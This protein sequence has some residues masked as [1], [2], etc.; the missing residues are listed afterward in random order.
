M[1]YFTQQDHTALLEAKANMQDADVALQRLYRRFEDLHQALYPKLRKHG[2]DL[3]AN[4]EKKGEITFSSCA[5]PFPTELMTLTYTRSHNQAEIIEAI[6]GRE[7]RPIETHCHPVIEIR[8]TEN[9]FAV[10]FV[11]SPQARQD[12]QNFAGK[13]SVETQRENFYKLLRGMKHDYS[14]GFWSGAHLED[15]HLS[16]GNMPPA[17]IMNQWLETFAAGRDWLRIGAWFT[18]ED[19]SLTPD[20]FV[21]E[22][23]QRISELY[24]MYEFVAWTSNNNFQEFYKRTLAKTR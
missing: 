22:V 2:I 12:Q 19:D 23:F 1:T 11:V 4:L 3:H 10:E 17:R 18:V 13:L 15:M 24:A 16:T 8:L 9:A 6:M 7:N 21:N 14:M 20:N 5:S